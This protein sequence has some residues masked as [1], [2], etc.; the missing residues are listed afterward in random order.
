M[1]SAGE[2]VILDLSLLVANLSGDAVAVAQ[3][4]DLF[5]DQARV[6]AAQLRCQS[7]ASLRRAV[8]HALRGSALT[9]G[10]NCLAQA[11]EQA[12]AGGGL[13]AVMAALDEAV[14]AIEAY[15]PAV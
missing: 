9:V 11:C 3:V 12:E 6:Y 2:V 1:R 5:C 13:D 14:A 7:E 10:A 15:D 4:L 8:V